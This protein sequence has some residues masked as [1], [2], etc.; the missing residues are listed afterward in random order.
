MP[1]TKII[2]IAEHAASGRSIGGG[3]DTSAK[4]R[5]NHIPMNVLKLII[6]PRWIFAIQTKK[7]KSIFTPLRKE[8]SV[9]SMSEIVA[10]EIQ[11]ITRCSF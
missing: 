8:S 3:R 9:T 7:L 2:R 4:W 5:V 6:G 10:Y 1:F 11:R